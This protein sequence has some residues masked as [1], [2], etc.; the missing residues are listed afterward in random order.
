MLLTWI[1]IAMQFYFLSCYALDV[2]TLT[3]VLCSLPSCHE[4]TLA[5]IFISD[6]IIKFRTVVIEHEWLIFTKMTLLNNM[7]ILWTSKN[8]ADFST[9]NIQKNDNKKIHFNV[10]FINFDWKL[11]LN[12]LMEEIRGTSNATSG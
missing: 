11:M 12:V 8:I 2:F 3:N 9:R 6:L 7:M 10:H 4:L 1:L 5:Q